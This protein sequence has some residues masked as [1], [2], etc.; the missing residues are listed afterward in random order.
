MV[1]A[2]SLSCWRGP[3][4]ADASVLNKLKCVHSEINVLVSLVL[5]LRGDVDV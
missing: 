4:V 5:V 2:P 3:L 1:S